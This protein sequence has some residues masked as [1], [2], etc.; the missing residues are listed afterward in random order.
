MDRDGLSLAEEEIE[1]VSEELLVLDG[2][3]LLLRVPVAETVLETEGD[4]VNVGDPE[5]GI[6]IVPAKL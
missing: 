3:A 1:R 4:R 5:G 2:L 6:P